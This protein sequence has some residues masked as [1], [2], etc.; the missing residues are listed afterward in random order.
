[1]DTRVWGPEAWALLHGLPWRIDLRLAEPFLHALANVLPCVH[2][3]Q[4][5]RALLRM[6]PVDAR[7]PITLADW[8]WRVHNAVNAKLGKPQYPFEGVIGAPVAEDDWRQAAANFA[9]FAALNYPAAAPSAAQRREHRVW[10]ELLG[11][12][13]EFDTRGLDAALDGRDQLYDWLRAALQLPDDRALIEQVR[14]R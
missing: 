5:L 7:Q 6:R 12:V 11:R 10:F 3:R 14:I 2:C 13:L 1:M 8:T 9:S 4:A